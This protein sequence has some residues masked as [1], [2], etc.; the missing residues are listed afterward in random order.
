VDGEGC[1]KSRRNAARSSV[2][3]QV[4]PVAVHG[5]CALWELSWR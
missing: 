3:L 1:A 5:N 4:K 2:Q